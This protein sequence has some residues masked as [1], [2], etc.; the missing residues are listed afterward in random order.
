MMRSLFGSLIIAL[1]LSLVVSCGSSADSELVEA[2][3]WV[4]ADES[5]F[6]FDNWNQINEDFGW[7]AEEYYAEEWIPYPYDDYTGEEIPSEL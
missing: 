4:P 6:T 7:T 5:H 2:L 1:M 3:S